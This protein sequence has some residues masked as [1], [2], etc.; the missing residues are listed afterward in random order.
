MITCMTWIIYWKPYRADYIV[1]VLPSTD[2]TKGLLQ[3]E[4]FKAMK[5]STA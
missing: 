1:S 3:K 2:E 5:E 4:H